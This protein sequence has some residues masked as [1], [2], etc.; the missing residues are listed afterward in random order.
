MI[1]AVAGIGGFAFEPRQASLLSF[2]AAGIPAIALAA[3]APP[4]ATPHTGVLRSLVRFTLPATLVMTIIGVGMYA[5]YLAPTD[6]AYL[7]QHPVVTSADAWGVTLLRAQSM[8]TSF[9]IFCSL[10]LI[11]LT[12]PPVRFFTGGAPLRRDWKPTIL[13]FLLLIGYLVVANVHLGQV[14]FDIVPLHWYEFCLAGAAALVW[15][16]IVRWLWRSDMLWRFLGLRPETGQ[17]TIGL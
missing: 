14:S 1:A 4:G 10:L 2:F 8:L 11:P 7:T 9:A 13:A 17:P 12:V 6:H 15:G 16:F 5:G 3:W